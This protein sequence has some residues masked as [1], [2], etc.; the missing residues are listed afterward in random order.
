MNKHDKSIV[1]LVLG[2]AALA[3][4]AYLG[5]K[6]RAKIKK[7]YNTAKESVVDGVGIV[8]VVTAENIQTAKETVYPAVA[9]AK[10]KVE[11]TMIKLNPKGKE[12]KPKTNVTVPEQEVTVEAEDYAFNPVIG[13]E[14][15]DEIIENMK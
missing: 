13:M 2:T 4:S 5:Y 14:S 12:K 9:G 6:N 15:Y 8:K 7:G 11:Q 3:G 10:D 1:G